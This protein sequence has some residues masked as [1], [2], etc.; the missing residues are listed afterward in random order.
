[1][2]KSDYAITAIT[3]IPRW[4]IWAAC[5]YARNHGI[6]CYIFLLT[7]RLD[8]QAKAEAKIT[9]LFPIFCRSKPNENM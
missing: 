8:A 7:L 5:R 1:M 4:G 3:N 9:K 2:T 6:P